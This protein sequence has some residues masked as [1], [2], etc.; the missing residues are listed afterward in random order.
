MP[1]RKKDHDPPPGRESQRRAV[2]HGHG[3][4]QRL[5]AKLEHL[6]RVKNVHAN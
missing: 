3:Q 5:R 1:E 6:Q 2:N 4:A